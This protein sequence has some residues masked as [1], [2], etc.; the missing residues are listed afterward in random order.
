[1]LVICINAPH[2]MG[3]INSKTSKFLHGQLQS[4]DF[5][6][7]FLLLSSSLQFAHTWKYSSTWNY[8]CSFCGALLFLGTDM[9]WS[10]LVHQLPVGMQNFYMKKL[11]PFTIAAGHMN[12]AAKYPAPVLQHSA[13]PGWGYLHSC[14]LSPRCNRSASDFQPSLQ[15]LPT[16]AGQQGFQRRDLQP[17]SLVQEH[18]QSYPLITSYQSWDHLL[19]LCFSSSSLDAVSP[20]LI[21]FSLIFNVI[22]YQT[23]SQLSNE[24]FWS[25]SQWLFLIFMMTSIDLIHVKHVWYNI[26]H[27]KILV[28]FLKFKRLKIFFQIHILIYCP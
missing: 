6:Y 28:T 16:P 18:P 14:P 23:T 4:F 11:Q 27:L 21:S 22:P 2:P 13:E 7:W 12:R 24:G 8:P 3:L 17:S 25:L 9:F 1:M 15:L 19:L 5:V 10:A 26:I 20:H